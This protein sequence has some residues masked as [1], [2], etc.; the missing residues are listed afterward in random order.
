MQTPDLSKPL[1]FSNTEAAFKYLSD[2]ELKSAYLLFKTFGYPSLVKYGPSLAS[3]ALSW[4]LPVKGLIKKTIFNHFCGGE[5]IIDCKSK[6]QVLDQYNVKTILDYSVEGEESEESFEKTTREIQKTI[7]ASAKNNAIPFAVF[8]VTGIGSFAL[9]QK[10]AQKSELNAVEKLAFEKLKNRV[11]SLCQK[12]ADLKVSL[13]IDAE[14]SWIQDAIDEIVMEM[15]HK[16]NQE[17]VIVYNTLQM[18]RHDRLNYLKNILASNSIKLGFKLV[19]G[20]YMEKERERANQKGYVSPIQPNKEATDN[21]YDT[22]VKLC[23]DSLDRCSLVIGSHNEESCLRAS[24]YMQSKG[25]KVD[26]KRVYFSQLLG[27]SDTLSF[28]L[29]AAG[30]NVAKYV[31]YGP[32]EAVLPYLSRRAQENSSVKGQSSRELLLIQKELRRRNKK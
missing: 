17:N 16:F 11:E 26:D 28:N 6:I 27:M 30:Y 23:M 21:D 2:A 15:S 24:Q 3:F 10:I 29:S 18:Y 13:M 9:L 32:I 20:A 12:A 7:E 4:K 25:I 19:R 31:P 22:A 1:D 8:K 14:E 5:S